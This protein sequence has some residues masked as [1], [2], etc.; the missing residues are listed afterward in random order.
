[1][2]ETTELD[3]H[4]ILFIFRQRWKWILSGFII[5]LAL[6]FVTSSFLIPKKY[7]SSVSLYVNNSQQKATSQD[8][9]NQ[10]DLNASQQLVNTYIVILE[11]DRVMQSIADKLSKP[12][13]VGQMK[14]AVHMESANKT[15]VLS[16]SAETTNPELSAEICNTIAD[17]APD[18]LKR[19]VKA[20]SVEVIGK[21]TPAS[22]PSS[23]NV[24]K[25]SAIGALIG[26]MIMIIVSLLAEVLDTTIKGEE[27]VK[28]RLNIPVL[29]E[30]P[31]LENQTR[32]GGKTDEAKK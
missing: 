5:G 24:A 16:I 25:Q 32:A 1:M 27:D 3:L 4:R 10:D 20:G 18:V 30:I 17:V 6:M 26:L 28:K 12:V 11:D 31:H 19:V 29:G 9:V 8:T 2:N 22:S 13:S 15:E 14:K 23:P 7:T 21:A